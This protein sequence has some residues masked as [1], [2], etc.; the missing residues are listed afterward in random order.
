MH[1]LIVVGLAMLLV[2]TAAAALAAIPEWPAV[3]PQTR[4]NPRSARGNSGKRT[5]S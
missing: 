3:G 5:P 2:G 1:K 4:S